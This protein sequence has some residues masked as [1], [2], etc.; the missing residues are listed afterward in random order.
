MGAAAIGALVFLVPGI[1]AFCWP[2]S[3]YE[4][5]ATFPPYNQ[6]LFHDLGAFQLG[7]GA[8]LV[9]AL[10]WTDA[11]FVALA[12]GS[13]GLVLHAL[14]HFLDHDLGGRDSD[15]W[16]LSLLGLAVLIGLALRAPARNGASP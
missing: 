12:G 16:V 2:R 8:A 3:F 4:N 14:S 6:H 15:P 10:I 5:I 13:A 11:L 1:W 9:A 7:I